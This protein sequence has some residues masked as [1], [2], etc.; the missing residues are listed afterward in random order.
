MEWSLSQ[1]LTIGFAAIV[2]LGGV[3]GYMKTGSKMSLTAGGVS[4]AALYFVFTQLPVHPVLASSIG[5][6]GFSLLHG[7][8]CFVVTFDFKAVSTVLLG[9]MGSRF[10]K[11]GKIFP[12]GVVSLTSL[13]MAGGYVHGIIRTL[14]H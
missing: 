6:E 9:V 5:L 3:M 2:G 14:T 4:A 11:S 7:S 8:N 1:K 13:I 12:A 10:K